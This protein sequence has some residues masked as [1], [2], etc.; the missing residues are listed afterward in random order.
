MAYMLGELG[1]TRDAG[2]AREY[3]VRFMEQ[4]DVGEELSR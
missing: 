3:E 1:L 4:S 2:L